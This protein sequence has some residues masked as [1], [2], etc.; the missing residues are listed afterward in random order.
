M[1]QQITAYLTR[2]YQSDLGEEEAREISG[3]M[4][5]AHN[6]EKI[7]DAVENLSKLTSYNFV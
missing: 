2:I 6:I 1:K 3:F 7:G 5:M 4:R